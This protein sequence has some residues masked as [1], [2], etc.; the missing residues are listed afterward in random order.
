[1]IRSLPCFPC[2]TRLTKGA[3]CVRMDDLAGGVT[4]KETPPVRYWYL[5][6]DESSCLPFS[7]HTASEHPCNIWKIS[8]EV[9]L[10]DSSGD[11]TA[12]FVS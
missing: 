11:D 3:K 5:H 10:V 12:V 1:M 8:E 6:E 4:R 9:S 2:N 7:A